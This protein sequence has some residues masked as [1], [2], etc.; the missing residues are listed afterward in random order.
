[1]AREHPEERAHSGVHV[2][3]VHDAELPEDEGARP[4][5]RR[6]FEEEE[7]HLHEQQLH[8]GLPVRVFSHSSRSPGVWWG[9]TVD[10]WTW[11]WGG[12]EGLD[13]RLVGGTTGVDNTS[14]A[15]GVTGRVDDMRLVTG[16]FWWGCSARCGGV[17]SSDRREFTSG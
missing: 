15:R 5:G 3:V 14:L 8:D 10:W 6:V 4:D 13:T 9:T 1:M 16:L 11:P 2:V 12:R 17:L 7:G